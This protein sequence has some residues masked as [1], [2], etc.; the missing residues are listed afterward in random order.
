M[1]IISNKNFFFEIKINFKFN[2]ILV[3]KI[4]SYNFKKSISNICFLIENF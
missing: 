4:Q 3:K 1:K 2:N